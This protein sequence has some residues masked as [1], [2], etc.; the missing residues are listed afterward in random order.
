MSTIFGVAVSPFVRKAILAHAYKGVQFEIKMLPPGDEDAEF[1]QAS[2][3]GKIPGYKT[4]NGALFSD[5]SVIIAYLE[6]VHAENP[7]YPE[8][9]ESL[10]RALWFEE[11][12]D[13]K[14]A[15]ACN[16]LYFQLIVGPKFFG[17]SPDENRIIEI[18]KQLL[19]RHLIISTVKCLLGNGLLTMSFLLQISP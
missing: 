1:R 12:A 18:R 3:L 19:P 10:A 5:S 15:E 11:Y 8:N 14:L 2:P 6:K 4:D 7:L 17:H 13:S 16:A 9:P